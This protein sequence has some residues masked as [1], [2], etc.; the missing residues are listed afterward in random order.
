MKITKIAIN[1]GYTNEGLRAA[2]VKVGT[3]PPL[4]F[5]EPTEA[6]LF[7]QLF[8]RLLNIRLPLHEIVNNHSKAI[9]SDKTNE[10]N[11]NNDES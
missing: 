9:R 1:H 7:A 8:D 4:I 6:R 10:D 5:N 3:T 11:P 2:S